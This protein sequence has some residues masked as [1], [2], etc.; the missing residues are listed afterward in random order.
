MAELE[1]RENLALLGD[2]AVFAGLFIVPAIVGS[3]VYLAVVV[4]SFFDLLAQGY[5]WPV[6]GWSAFGCFGICVLLLLRLTDMVYEKI[7]LTYRAS[8]PNEMLARR[9][10][11][12]ARRRVAHAERMVASHGGENG[13]LSA[14]ARTQGLLREAEQHMRSHPRLAQNL[15]AETVERASNLAAWSDPWTRRDRR[16]YIPVGYLTRD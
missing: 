11:E 13:T 14:L 8:V 3:M 6:A 10:I 4:A 2:I 12:E 9:E 15:A 1:R 7:A 16:A 5:A